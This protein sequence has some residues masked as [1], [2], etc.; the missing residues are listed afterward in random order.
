MTSHNYLLFPATLLVCLSLAGCNASRTEAARKDDAK[1]VMQLSVQ[2]FDSAKEIK[3]PWGWIRWLMSSELD[4]AA[5]QTFGIVQIEAGQRNPLHQ[6][7][8]CEELLYV[9]SGSLENVVGDKRV[10]THAGEILRVPAGIPHQGINNTNEPM[11]AV[12]S[13]SSGTRQMVALEAKTE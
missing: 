9:L 11:R 8:N 6:H 5:S 4:P 10:V 2:K 3:Y 12:I 13:Y 1:T 7:P